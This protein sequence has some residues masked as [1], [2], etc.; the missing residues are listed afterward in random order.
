MIKTNNDKIGEEGNKVGQKKTAICMICDEEKDVSWPSYYSHVLDNRLFLGNNRI[1]QFSSAGGESNEESHVAQPLRNRL[2][3]SY[4][5]T[6]SK[7]L[8]S[9]IIPC[10]SNGEDWAILFEVRGKIRASSTSLSMV[11]CAC[12]APNR[13]ILAIRR[14]CCRFSLPAYKGVLEYL[15]SRIDVYLFLLISTVLEF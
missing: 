9:T 5:V 13:A 10:S 1:V 14:L 8:C 2:V 15:F 4:W 11:L 3:A 6:S 12:G 7:C